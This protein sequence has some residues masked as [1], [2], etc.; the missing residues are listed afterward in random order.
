MQ[1]LGA[2]YSVFH[3]CIHKK[4]TVKALVEAVVKSEHFK[5]SPCH[6]LL[7][8]GTTTNNIV[9]HFKVSTWKI[10]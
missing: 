6:L 4:E 8:G 7:G 1:T 5:Q 9:P 3:A 2:L 10:T